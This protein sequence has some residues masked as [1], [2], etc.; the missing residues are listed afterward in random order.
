LKYNFGERLELGG[1]VFSHARE[2]FAAAQTRASTMVDLGGYYNFKHHPGRQFLCCYGHSAAG[3][4]E[5]YAYVG[6]YWT[7]RKNGSKPA[8][9]A[10][11]QRPLNA[12]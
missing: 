10:W 2:G 4:T 5:N 1:E 7:W 9:H 11:L 8:G 12:E 6:I 3:Q